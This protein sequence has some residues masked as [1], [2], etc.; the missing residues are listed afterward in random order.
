[1]LFTGSI[2]ACIQSGLGSVAGGSV[3]A[4]LQSAG[5]GGY[6]LSVVY[7]GVQ[8]LGGIVASSAA[9][10]LAFGTGKKP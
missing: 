8:A 4:T 9:G 5:A 6:G 2:A 3:F 7:G 10:V 1:M